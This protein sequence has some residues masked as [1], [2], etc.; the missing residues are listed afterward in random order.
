MGSDNTPKERTILAVRA[1]TEYLGVQLTHTRSWELVAPLRSLQRN[2]AGCLKFRVLFFQKLHLGSQGGRTPG[3][4]IREEAGGSPQ[5]TGSA[6]AL[7]ACSDSLHLMQETV[8][9]RQG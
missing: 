7:H 8:E 4:A 5:E 9:L 3:A 1:G 6:E 2:P